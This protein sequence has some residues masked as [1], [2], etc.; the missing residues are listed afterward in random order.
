MRTGVVKSLFG[1][2]VRENPSPSTVVNTIN[3]ETSRFE[4]ETFLTLFYAVLDSVSL[5]MTYVNAGHPGP[6]LFRQ[7]GNMETLDSSAPVLGAGMELPARPETEV[8][9]K[10]G[11]TLALY[12]DGI[13]E[14]MDAKHSRFG[15]EGL[16]NAIRERSDKPPQHIADEVCRAARNFASGGLPLDD[17]TAIILQFERPVVGGEG[18]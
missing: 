6:L 15:N 8:Q 16:A 4:G 12:T 18:I 13:I 3:E 17:L 10:W 7:G 2:A 1:R 11:D 14:A 9:L 5:S